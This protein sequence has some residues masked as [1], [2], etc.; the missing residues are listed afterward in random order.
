MQDT[1]RANRHGRQCKVR[2]PDEPRRQ[3]FEYG[4][5]DADQSRHGLKVASNLGADK[6]LGKLPDAN[7][8]STGMRLS[9]AFASEASFNLKAEVPNKSD[10]I[11]FDVLHRESPRGSLRSRFWQN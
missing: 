6:I 8:V 4:T 5:G 7:D 1:T 9:A 10:V 3:Y 2:S 11:L